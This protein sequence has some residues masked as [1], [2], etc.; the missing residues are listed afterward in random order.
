MGTWC[1][2]FYV[3]VSLTGIRRGSGYAVCSIGLSLGVV[4]VS[5]FAQRSS[6][7]LGHRVD[8]C[9]SHVMLCA[10]CG[11]SHLMLCASFWMSSA[12]SVMLGHR[13]MRVHRVWSLELRG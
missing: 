2:A 6:L 7:M 10:S 13:L 3:S 8:A 5:Y 9:A 12:S 1:S 4:E 11:S